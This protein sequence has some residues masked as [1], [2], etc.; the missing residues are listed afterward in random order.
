MR[1]Y[2]TLLRNGRA[3]RTYAFVL[4]KHPCPGGRAAVALLSLG[5]D[6]TQPLLA[7]IV[8]QLPGSRGQAMGFNV[9]TLFI[10]FGRGSLLFQELLRLGALAGSDLVRHQRGACDGSGRGRL[11]HRAA[12]GGPKCRGS[13]CLTF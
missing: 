6:L 9:F 12:P 7:G 8:T 10:G 5:Y 13:I 3:I 11:P 1:G 4:Y 2:L